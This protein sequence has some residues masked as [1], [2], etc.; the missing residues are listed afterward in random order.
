MDWRAVIGEILQEGGGLATRQQL[1][2]RIPKAVLDRHTR[3]NLVRVL[4]H[5]Y[6][7]RDTAVDEPTF[8]RA[9]L[10]HVGPR[11]AL[12]H[13]TALCMWGLWRLERPVH[14]VVDQAVRRAGSPDVVVHRRLDF[15]PEAPQSLERRGLPV[16]DLPRTLI[17]SW[18]LLPADERRP[19]LL[20]TARRGLVIAPRLRSALD[21]RSNIAGHRL[22]AQAIDLIEDGCQ[23][24][25][26]A[27]GILDV[28]R[29]PSLPRGV[30]QHRVIAGG[31]VFRLDR[32]WPEVKLAVELDG[33]RHHTSP[34][35]RRRD[36][37]RD[38]ALAAAGWVVLR[39]TYAD[40][41]RDPAKVRARVLAVY[42]TRK[43]QLVAV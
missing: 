29:H 22:L 4:P 34:E 38:A 32:A 13:T 5:V 1:L 20:E 27:V 23:S 16:T 2:A 31:V 30:G 42:R 28:F 35:D 12:S 19:L 37:A 8:L 15:T 43:A 7:W 24:E 3:R 39:F 36:L 40:V 10:L 21:E 14:L 18:P 25:L 26:E 33:A 41:R 9:A 11:S 17:D 6:R